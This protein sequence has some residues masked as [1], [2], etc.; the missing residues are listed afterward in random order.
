MNAR[1]QLKDSTKKLDA[2]PG[3]PNARIGTGRFVRN[4]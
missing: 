1:K 4:L 3:Q 2:A